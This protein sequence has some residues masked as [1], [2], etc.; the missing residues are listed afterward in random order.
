MYNTGLIPLLL[1]LLYD[2]TIMK[3]YWNGFLDC[4]KDKGQLSKEYQ[5]ESLQKTE[6]LPDIIQTTTK[7]TF[8]ILDGHIWKFKFEEILA[9]MNLTFKNPGDIIENWY[10]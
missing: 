8:G 3:H 7:Y 9:K 10:F 1:P 6:S 5:T 4:L 2:S